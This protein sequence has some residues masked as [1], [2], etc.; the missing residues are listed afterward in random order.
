MTQVGHLNVNA[1]LCLVVHVQDIKHLISVRSHLNCIEVDL[2]L[3]KLFDLLLNQASLGVALGVRISTAIVILYTMAWCIGNKNGVSAL[4]LPILLQSIFES[5]SNIFWSISTTNGSQ[6]LQELMASLNVITEVKD[7]SNIFAV[8]VISVGD[9]RDA[10]LD[11][12][13]LVSDAVND[14]F[15]FLLAGINP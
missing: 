6:L 3:C 2:L 9:N 11:V 10:N 4:S 8:A 14:S 7:L 15:D 5:S 13:M 12:E 1:H